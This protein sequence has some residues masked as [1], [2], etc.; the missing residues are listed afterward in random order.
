MGD[1]SKSGGMFG[2][3]RR[4]PSESDQRVDVHALGE[5]A[6]GEIQSKPALFKAEAPKEAL[7]TDDVKLRD[8]QILTVQSLFGY[9]AVVSVDRGVFALDAAQQKVAAVLRVVDGK[10]ALVWSNRRRDRE[11]LNVVQQR[12]TA[13][14]VALEQYE[15]PPGIIALLYE[16][17]NGLTPARSS[18]EGSAPETAAND[19]LLAAVRGRASDIHILVNAISTRVQLR[20]DGEL[21]IVGHPLTTELGVAIART[22]HARANDSSKRVSFSVTEVHDA[23]IDTSLEI[24]AG[25]NTKVSLRFASCPAED[26]VDVVLRV[27]MVGSPL[28][29]S[30]FEKLGYD[31][32]QIDVINRMVL[33]PRGIILM[34]GETGSGKTTTLAH[35]A[36]KYDEIHEGSAKILTLEDPVELVISGATQTSIVRGEDSTVNPFTKYMRSA[37]RRDPD[38]ILVSEV[39]DA[40]SAMLAF[41]CA[42]TGHKLLS[43]FHAN[44]FWSAVERLQ[45]SL[46]I[47]ATLLGSHNLFTGAVAQRL[48]PL[49]CNSCAVPL[50]EVSIQRIARGED[51]HGM[52]ANLLRQIRSKGLALDKVR[53]KSTYGCPD[54]EGRG[55]KGR[56][57]AAE[58]VMVDDHIEDLI[59]QNNLGA[60]RKYW[61]SGQSCGGRFSGLG[62]TALGQA[63]EKMYAGLVA[64]ADVVAKFGN[65]D[66]AEIRAVRPPMYV[67]PPGRPA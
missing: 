35:M 13:Q 11:I 51:L 43:T 55:R 12:A 2:W 15:S 25:I 61:E 34:L 45:H 8:L 50:D 32:G 1:E 67:V 30:D 21:E 19:L 18:D 58:I 38:C 59:S 23:R 22:L 46:K 4:K 29:K 3:L 54:C 37:M 41:E 16:R 17:P 39:R 24:E 49:L 56:T 27:L 20:I 36:L 64:P 28:S 65:L 53:L 63:L 40:D 33:N 5:K 44:D 66:E 52:N 10:Y 14:G 62:R 6:D 9:E 47:P 31:A 26:G 42:Q 7:L 60:A 57:V 48:I